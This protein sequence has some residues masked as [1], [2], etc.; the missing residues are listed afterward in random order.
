MQRVKVNHCRYYMCPTA[1]VQG[2]PSVGGRRAALPFGAFAQWAAAR[3]P[4]GRRV[5]SVARKLCPSASRSSR[6]RWR[7]PTSCGSPEVFAPDLGVGRPSFGGRRATALLK[8]GECS[9]HSK[10]RLV[11][12]VIK[13]LGSTA[14]ARQFGSYNLH[15]AASGLPNPALN[16]TLCGGP[17][18]VYISFQP[19]IGPPQ[20]AG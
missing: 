12:I 13:P 5:A 16:L 15:P 6:A 9:G 17:I 4:K 19:K 8:L 20:S 7:G 11:A 10:H 1:F 3:Q 14:L 2:R 18:L